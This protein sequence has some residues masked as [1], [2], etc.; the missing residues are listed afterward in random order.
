MAKCGKV[1][2]V[3]ILARLCTCPLTRIDKLSSI[4]ALLCPESWHDELPK[5]S[6]AVSKDF[7]EHTWGCCRGWGGGYLSFVAKCV[8]NPVS[9]AALG[10]RVTSLGSGD[11]VVLLS[12]LLRKKLSAAV[13]GE[14]VTNQD[15]YD[16]HFCLLT[17]MM[18][19]FFC[20]PLFL[21][22]FLAQQSYLP[23]AVCL[24][25]NILGTEQYSA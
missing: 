1:H 4:K 5:D 19:D 13:S 3:G 23:Q 6:D 24:N 25:G 12:F 10:G 17:E 14:P 16:C 21:S 8:S 9:C 15:C 20:S 2:V 7:G 18:F 22:S 11:P